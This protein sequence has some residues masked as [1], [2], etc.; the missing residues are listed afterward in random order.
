M[1]QEKVLFVHKPNI[2]LH[3]DRLSHSTP[4]SSLT[5][6]TSSSSSPSSPPVDPT[7]VTLVNQ[8]SPGPLRGFVLLNACAVVDPAQFP[9][10]EAFAQHCEAVFNQGYKEAC[11][12]YDEIVVLPPEDLK[13]KEEEEKKKSGVKEKSQ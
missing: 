1:I 10:W 9:S 2:T 3:S 8:L 13:E 4:S 7:A 6:P 12:R 5:S 11:A